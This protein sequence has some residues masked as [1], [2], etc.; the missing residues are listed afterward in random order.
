MSA[1]VLNRKYE[2]ALPTSYVDVDSEEMEYIDG[3][4][5]AW[6]KALVATAIVA[7]GAGLIVALSYGQVWV[8]AKIMGYTFKTAVRKLGIKAV[9]GI[10]VESTGISAGA[11]AAA[12]AIV[13]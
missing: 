6:Q 7:A 11:V 10:V 12:L 1:F 3:G 8:A 4:Y 2:L 9:V 13:F 5:A